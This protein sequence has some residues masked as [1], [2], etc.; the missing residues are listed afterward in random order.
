MLVPRWHTP[1]VDYQ[2][3]APLQ[4]APRKQEAY[5]YMGRGFVNTAVERRVFIGFGVGST[6]E[7]RY[8]S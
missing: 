8:V 7:Q 4:R 6:I 1:L 5:I 3:I 2:Y